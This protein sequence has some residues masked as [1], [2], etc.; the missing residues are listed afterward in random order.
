M[1]APAGQRSAD[2]L[3]EAAMPAK[4]WAVML[5]AYFDESERADGIFA[6]AGLAYNK[7]QAKKC[8]REWNQLF[9]EYGECHMTDLALKKKQFKGISDREAH[10]LIQRATSIINKCSSFSVAI[11]CNIH[12]MEPLLP[13]WIHGFEGAYPVCCHYAMIALGELVG[14]EEE[15]AYFFESGHRHQTQSHSFMSRVLDVPELKRAYR[16]FSHT[17]ADKKDIQQ[18]Q[19]ADIL[20]WEWAKFYDETVVAE[21]RRMRKSLVSLITRGGMTVV[22]YDTGYFKAVH[23]TGRPLQDWC[24]KVT[25]VGLLPDEYFR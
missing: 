15:I 1:M 19:T 23:L 16:H 4:G 17:F 13:K 21:K 24:A 20:A 10:R 8:R 25:A 7:R 22:D 12:E 9:Q 5:Q 2:D 11:S 6:V 3:L 18:L 14:E